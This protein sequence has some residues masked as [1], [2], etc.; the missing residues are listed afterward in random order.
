MWQEVIAMRDG[1]HKELLD[2]L[3]DGVY[4]VDRYRRMTYWNKGAERLTGYTAE[5]MLGRCCWDG[6]LQHVTDDGVELC[7]TACPLARCIETGEELEAEVYCHHRNGHTIPVLVR[8]APIRDEFG[9]IIGA[10]EIFS[11]NSVKMMALSMVQELERAS[12]IDE[13]TGL[14]NRRY[15]MQ[16]IQDM[17]SRRD[18]FG[19]PFGVLFLDVDHFKAINDTHGHEVGDRVLQ[20]VADNLRSATRSVDLAGRW[21]GGELVIGLQGVDEDALQK[22]ANRVR[23]LIEQSVVRVG[24]DILRATVSV[25]AAL[26]RPGEMPN[27]V[28]ERADCYMYTSK[29]AGRNCVTCASGTLPNT[30]VL[31]TETPIAEDTCR[32]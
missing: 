5:S 2:N 12:Y 19:W 9:E 14:A 24:D 4:F 7:H 22:A 20:M 3:Y 17:A 32:D 11:D 26:A 29:G 30:C 13:L 8:A 31:R 6:L 27:G 28:I 10:V 1:F 15:A 21:G 23:A 16:G 18:R 25:G